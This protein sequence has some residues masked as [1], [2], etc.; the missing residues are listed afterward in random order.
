MFFSGFRE[1]D[2]ESFI[3]KLKFLVLTFRTLSIEVINIYKGKLRIIKY[4][5]NDQRDI[6]ASYSSNRSNW[7]LNFHPKIFSFNINQDNSFQVNLDQIILTIKIKKEM[8]KVPLAKGVRKMM[9]ISVSRAVYHRVVRT[10]RRGWH[11]WSTIPR[12]VHFL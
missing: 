11:T 4:Y 2:E 8:D 6:Y 7:F 12:A 9:K 1:E 3:V 5:F 10:F